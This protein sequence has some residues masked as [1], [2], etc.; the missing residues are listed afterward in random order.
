[1]QWSNEKR[2]KNKDLPNITQTLQYSMFTFFH[3]PQEEFVL[4]QHTCF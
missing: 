2:N 4:I 3:F 1:M